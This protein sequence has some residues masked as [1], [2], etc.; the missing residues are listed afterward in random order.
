M[1]LNWFTRKGIM[2]WPVSVIGWVIFAL[3]AAYTVYTFIDINSHAHSG[4]D[5]MIN[6]VFNL[7]IIGLIYTIIGYFT[8]RT[9]VD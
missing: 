4:S 3:A 2:Y 8:E 9:E 6:F 5:M 1:K 7:L